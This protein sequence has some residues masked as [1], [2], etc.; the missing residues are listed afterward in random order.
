MT[1]ISITS[2]HK[3]KRNAIA[4]DIAAFIAAGGKIQQ[5]PY[6]PDEYSE[7]ATVDL[8]AVKKEKAR[9][10]GMTQFNNRPA[11][12][13]TAKKRKCKHSGQTELAKK[14]HSQAV[15]T[16]PAGRARAKASGFKGE[17]A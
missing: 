12:Q 5:L 17:A 16:T 7:T 15:S 9:A 10:K 13:T 3:A 6:G 2:E 14:K 4:S 11:A 1:T 8:N